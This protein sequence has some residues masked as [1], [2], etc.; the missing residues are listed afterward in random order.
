MTWLLDPRAINVLII[1]L[2]LAAAIRWAIEK[3]WPQV[4]YWLSAAVLNISVT[5]MTP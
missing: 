2:F 1:A 3:N 5:R 4:M